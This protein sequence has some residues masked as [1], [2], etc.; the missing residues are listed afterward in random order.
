MQ[1]S[2][3]GEEMFIVFQETKICYENSDMLRL[4]AYNVEIEI[5]RLQIVTF[6]LQ[7]VILS[8][9]TKNYNHNSKKEIVPC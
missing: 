2:A 9:I 4:T 3:L 6:R 8:E 7:P 5:K 1:F